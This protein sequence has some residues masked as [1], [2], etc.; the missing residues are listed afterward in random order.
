MK[1]TKKQIMLDLMKQSEGVSLD[2]LMAKLNWQRHTI[3]G[4][5]SN[6][7]KA[8]Y[9][10]DSGIDEDGKKIYY[11][12]EEKSENKPIKESS[13]EP[14]KKAEGKKEKLDNAKTAGKQEKLD[15]TKTETKTNA[16]NKD[17]KDTKCKK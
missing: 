5:I 14:L 13:V 3:C 8:G 4:S 11:L 16:S 9:D 15:S 1:L 6:L 10:I 7:K 2:E 17:K 12:N